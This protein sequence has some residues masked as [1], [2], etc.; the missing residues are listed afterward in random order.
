MS[1]STSL[2]CSELSHILSHSESVEDDLLGPVLQPALSVLGPHPPPALLASC[3]SDKPQDICTSCNIFLLR[4]HC[5]SPSH[6]FCSL[7]KCHLF[8]NVIPSYL[9][10]KIT[11]YSLTV[12][13]Y[14]LSSWSP[15]SIIWV[16]NLHT[17]YFEYL[18]LSVNHHWN[19]SFIAS[20]TFS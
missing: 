2:L 19:L 8:N 13:P 1:P 15:F 20:E 7:H 3:H 4:Y 16:T 11:I 18:L 17:L 6:L 9:V 12:T 5:G 14:A 10:L